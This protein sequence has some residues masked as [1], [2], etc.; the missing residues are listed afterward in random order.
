[1]SFDHSKEL[2]FVFKWICT[3][4]SVTV[5]AADESYLSN[6]SWSLLSMFVQ[7]WKAYHVEKDCVFAVIPVSIILAICGKLTWRSW[8]TAYF[9]SLT[10]NCQHHIS[11]PPIE[12]FSWFM[13]VSAC[14]IHASV[15]VNICSY[16]Y[17]KSCPL[18]LAHT[19]PYL[20]HQYDCACGS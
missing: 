12:V 7:L 5:D 2:K 8:W 14:K 13:L 15:A 20:H 4:F 3:L 10:D 1:M 11:F 6:D 18:F 16:G 19:C 17:A 9:W